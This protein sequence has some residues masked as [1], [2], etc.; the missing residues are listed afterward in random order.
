MGEDAITFTSI[1]DT[2]AEYNKLSVEIDLVIVTDESAGTFNFN[3]VKSCIRRD[4]YKNLILNY[5]PEYIQYYQ[6]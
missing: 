3:A 5:L 2:G 1:G 4:Y 6:L